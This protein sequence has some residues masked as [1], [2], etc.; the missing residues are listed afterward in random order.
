[1][2]SNGENCLSVKERTSTDVGSI[3]NERIQAGIL[4]SRE[5][6]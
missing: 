1:M 6:P 4:R 5:R 2:Q 3:K